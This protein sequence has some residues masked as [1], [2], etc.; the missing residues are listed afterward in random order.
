MIKR[1]ITRLLHLLIIFI[2]GVFNAEGQVNNQTEKHYLTGIGAEDT[3][4]WDFYCSK[5][6][7]SNK[8]TTIEV[9]SCWEQQQF[10]EYNYGHVPFEDRAKETGTYKRMFDVPATWKGQNITIVFEGVMTDATVKINGKLAGPTHQGAFY[11]FKYDI[12]KLLFY[13]KSNKIEVIVKKFSG[14]KSINLAE[15]KADFWVFGGI[16]RPVYLRV[17]PKE[18]INRVAIDAKADGSFS[19]QCVFFF[20][21]KNQRISGKHSNFRRQRNC[22]F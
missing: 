17:S 3:T 4:T 10:G 14:N 16:Y 19:S 11:E 20:I 7:N 1:N 21:K 9:P 22:R 13:G 5:G 2:I 8:W 12:S 18:N 6:M 15:R